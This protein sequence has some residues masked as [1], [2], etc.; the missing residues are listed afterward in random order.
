[1]DYYKYEEK[2]SLKV[3][4]WLAVA[5]AAGIILGI[6]CLTSFNGREEVSRLN[7]SLIGKQDAGFDI[8]IKGAVG[9]PGIYHIHSEITLRDL[10]AISGILPNADL[11]RFNLDT[12]VKKG[13]ILNVPSKAMINVHLEGAVMGNQ[14]LTVPKNYRLMDLI[15]IGKFAPEADLNFLKKKRKLK[16]DEVIHVPITEKCC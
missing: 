4:E 15:D 9:N 3:H 6:T 8:L 11:R 5:T 13:R 14:M 12:V 7:T 2:S 16:P 1:M 10:L